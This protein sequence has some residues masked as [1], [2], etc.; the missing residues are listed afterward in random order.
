MT[1]K[2]WLQGGVLP[3]L[4]VM[5]VAGVTVAYARMQ[6]SSATSPLSYDTAKRFDGNNIDMFVTNEGS[7]GLNQSTG[8]AGL[9]Y[10]K[11]TENTALFAAGIWIGAKVNGDIRVRVAEYA[12]TYVPGPIFTS[13]TWGD[14]AD[15]TYHVYKINAG[16]NAENNPNYKN[17]PV[18]DGAPTTPDGKPLLL[19][20]QTLWSVYNDLNPVASTNNA[21]TVA[22]LGVE[23]QQ[24]TFGFNR[25]GALGNVVFVSF[26]IIN[27]GANT[28]EDTYVSLWSDPDLGGSADDVV[29]CD[30]TLS[31]GYCY[32]ATNNDVNYGSSPPAIG[33]DF[34]QGPI[35]D[36][37][38]R[39]GMVSFNK[40]INGT[41][42]AAP[43]E[44]YN[45]MQG[46]SKTGEPVV[47]PTTG[48]VTRYQVPGDPVAG[49]GWLDNN[50]A[51]RRMM[52]SS[53]P[54]TM[55]PGDTQVVV[56]A[57]IVG[58]G[59]DRLTSVTALKFNDF[60]AQTAFDANFDLP[61]PPPRPVVHAAAL[62]GEI[63][64]QWGDLSETTYDEPGYLFEGYNV[65]AG[66]SVAGPWK[67]VATFDANNN[68]S[69]IF[70]DQFDPN[71][72]VVINQPV[73]FG[74]DGG[75][76][77]SF[78]TKSDLYNG[79][80]LA[81]DRPYFFAVTAYSY[82]AEEGAG[83]RTLE[84][85][86]EPARVVPQLLPAGVRYQDGVV[87][88]TL[89]VTRVS[90]TSDGVVFPIV[91]DPTMTTGDT[92]EITF[93]LD[94]TGPYWDLKT[95]SG[96]AV[97]TK[98]RNQ[99]GDDSYLIA[100]GIMWKVVGALPGFKHNKKGNPMID[101][102][103]G[104]GG[105]EVPPD[106]NRG[107]GNDVFHSYNSTRQWLLS[108]GGGDGGEGR[109]TRNG[110]DNANLTSSDLLMKWDG[111]PDNLGFW[112]L[113]DGAIGPLPFGFYLKDPV[114]NVET[115]L[116]PVLTGSAFT[117][118]V[119]DYPDSAQMSDPYSGWPCTDWCYPYTFTGTY[120]D[121][122]ADA[123]DNGVIDNDPRMN[124][125]CARLIV[126]WGDTTTAPTFPALGTVIKFTT[127]KPNSNLDSFRISTAGVSFNGTAAKNDL[128][129]VRVVPNPYFAHSQYELNQFYRSVKFTALPPECTIRIFNLAGD[130]IRT[131]QKTPDG[132]SIMEWNLLTDRYL[133]VGS[134]VYVYHIE[135]KDGA[136]TVGTTVGRMAVF[137]EKERLN[138]F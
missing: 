108:C 104:P 22:P 125:L 100:D 77:H 105:V 37:G 123:R 84:N 102:I 51:D 75:I 44:S 48:K 136:R 128:K 33:F 91:V 110:D 72:G 127:T 40:Y 42:A 56:G 122:L 25:T 26:K 80:E 101:E 135:A 10:P 60:F 46:L 115:R 81:N 24:T 20:D 93:G 92:Y 2:R 96:R 116:I 52:L 129:N 55:A 30:T 1:F 78:S 49:T 124:E 99:T 111:D 16:D 21:A 137:I 118:G 4:L 57:I 62:D 109:L 66:A 103:N 121:F 36:D 31:L 39:L 126:A 11:G 107:P 29:G 134:G 13:T 45:Y 98:Q 67:R 18:G 50:P 70:D 14:P 90:G 117:T 23:I 113:D 53:G 73:Q 76:K 87:G 112:A 131:L 85:S 63:V 47:D 89:A 8:N 95:S 132:T 54:F 138:T 88:D 64:L 59:K 38:N 82:G 17:W 35:G 65:Y 27:K 7:Y 71:T 86:I 58:Q 83:L 32:N 61:S 106:V 28:L 120:A 97:L 69:I 130:L 41:D 94:E 5:L 119:Y 9:I 79:G 12:D 19:G 15:T 68:V 133:P 74:N 3:G 34:F 43:Q 114:T 6:P